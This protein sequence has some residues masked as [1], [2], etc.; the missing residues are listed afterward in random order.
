MAESRRSTPKNDAKLSLV[1]RK[2]NDVDVDNLIGHLGSLEFLTARELLVDKDYQRMVHNRR[3]DQIVANYDADVFG[4]LYANQRDSG[5]IYLMDG[6]HRWEALRKMHAEDMKAPCYVVSGLDK[7]G[8]ARVFWKMN[9]FRLHPGSLDT[10][11]ARIQAG[12][13]DAVAIQ[14]IAWDLGLHLMSYPAAMGPNDVLAYGTLERIYRMGVLPD[15]ITI[16]REGWPHENG[17]FRAAYMMGVARFMIGF[18]TLFNVDHLRGVMAAHSAKAIESRALFYKTTL[19]S[20]SA[21]AFA[22]A[23]HHFYNE[24]ATSSQKL[25]HW[26][27]QD[28]FIASAVEARAK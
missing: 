25:P 21:T 17:A 3:V 27:D 15:V 24:H 19:N 26:G 14:Q 9:Q 1:Q 10:F 28:E 22:R 8:E 2:A 7:Q 13:S 18:R 6:Q 4:V 5:H 11:R 12:D 20:A 23:L 16:I